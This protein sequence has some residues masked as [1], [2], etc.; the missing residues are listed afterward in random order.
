[1]KPG[2]WVARYEAPDSEWDND[3][4]DWGSGSDVPIDSSCDL[5]NPEECES[6]Q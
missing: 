6:C 4:V 2:D 5:E 1:M 3:E